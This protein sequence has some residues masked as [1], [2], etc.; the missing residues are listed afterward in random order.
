MDQ[1]KVIDTVTRVTQLAQ[2]GAITGDQADLIRG[3]LQPQQAPPPAPAQ[4][5]TTT[6]DL[7]A[8]LS[9]LGSTIAQAQ[10]TSSKEF[11]EHV[12]RSDLAKTHPDRLA[13]EDALGAFRAAAGYRDG[14]STSVDDRYDSLVKRAVSNMVARAR[15]NQCMALEAIVS[16]Y[17]L[18]GGGVEG[19]ETERLVMLVGLLAAV[20]PKD[21]VRFHNA[22]VA[23]K[24]GPEWRNQFAANIVRMN[25]H[26]VPL[27][28]DHP[29]FESV[30]LALLTQFAEDRPV[31][32]GPDQAKKCFQVPPF[33]GEAWFPVQ[34]TAGGPAVNL[35]PV[36]T[37]YVEL[38]R[39]VEVLNTQMAKLQASKQY[40]PKQH[41]DYRGR[42]GWNAPGRGR[43]RGRS[44]GGRG[45][46]RGGQTEAE[47]PQ[48][49]RSQQ[50]RHAD[51][52]GFRPVLQ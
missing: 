42:G 7:A 29:V 39:K 21:W 9:S 4:P 3:S 19:E 1:Q 30:N 43:G 33:G 8:L 13:L 32:G 26:Q 40:E 11:L 15:N 24:R 27:Y 18:G 16:T 10:V 14:D 47:R 49:D 36:E 28:P 46:L 17:L 20:Q 6:A 48:E 2:A 52:Q 31:G 22:Y 35:T 41:D 38:S 37:S 12:R 25:Q 5:V 44:Y 50:A 51:P 34:Q 23:S 45:G